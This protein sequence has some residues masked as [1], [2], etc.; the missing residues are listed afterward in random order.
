MKGFKH[1]DDW[2]AHPYGCECDRCYKKFL[3]RFVEVLE[4][5]SEEVLK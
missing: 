4:D 1:E 2:Q 5:I 3:Q